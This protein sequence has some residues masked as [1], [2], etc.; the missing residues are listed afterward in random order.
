LLLFDILSE[1]IIFGGQIMEENE[2]VSFEKIIMA[3]V[4]AIT[5][6]AET[7]GDMLDELVKKGALSVEQGKALNEELKHD[8][9]KGVDTAVQKVQ[10]SA[11][12]RFIDNMGKF[13]PEDIEKIRAKLDEIDNAKKEPDEPGEADKEAD[14]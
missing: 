1:K 6:T 8:I 5:K 7:A 11:V 14:E 4:G 2:K 9:K 10:T 13:S 12:S 3:G